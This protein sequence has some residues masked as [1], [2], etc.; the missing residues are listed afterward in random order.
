MALVL[1]LRSMH[2]NR[3]LKHIMCRYTDVHKVQGLLPRSTAIKQINECNLLHYTKLKHKI[4]QAQGTETIDSLSWNKRR[5][6]VFIANRHP[7]ELTQKLLHSSSLKSVIWSGRILYLKKF[8]RENS[9]WK[10]KIY[11]IPQG[12]DVG[13]GAQFS[14]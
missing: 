3:R 5:E 4:H 1:R 8:V 10:F 9:A 6:L 11:D 7:W 14:P 2:T 12:Q 13:S